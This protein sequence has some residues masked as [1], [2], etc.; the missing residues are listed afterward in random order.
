MASAATT[1]VILFASDTTMMA[2]I[3]KR[4][5]W[6]ILEAFTPTSWSRK[7]LA[8][9]DKHWSPDSKAVLWI[10]WDEAVRAMPKEKQEIIGK[11]LHELLK[12]RTQGEIV[13][14]SRV[15]D[16]P[17]EAAR[18]MQYRL[19]RIHTCGLGM[20]AC[21]CFKAWSVPDR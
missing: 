9:I 11:R 7:I 14:E 3:A 16:W 2:T 21:V 5:K 10:H 17:K 20:K 4:Q 18:K 13:I 15:E 1:K 19:T 12:K 6:E 8:S